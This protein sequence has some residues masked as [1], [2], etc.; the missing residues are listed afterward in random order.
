MMVVPEGGSLFEHNMT[1]VVDGHTGVEHSI[2]VAKGYEDVRQLWSSTKVGY[3]P[4]LIV[5]YGGLWGEQYWY[6]KTNVWE[7]QRLSTF[8]PRRIIDSRSRRRT[9]APD[10][11]WNHLNNARLAGDLLHR[12]VSVQLGAHGQRE[13][14][15]AHW[16][17]WMFAQGGM[18]PLEVIRCATLNGARYLGLDKD[19][20]SLEPG[21]LAD[22]AVLDGNP[23][24]NIRNTETV[25][26]TVVNGRV[27]DA[28]TMNEI[29]NHPHTRQPF[30]FQTPGNEGWGRAAEAAVNA[31]DED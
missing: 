28:A 10:D 27:F 22:L 30:F 25:H 24:E 8:V 16:E 29:G 13:G 1:M 3:T 7:D 9:A 11:E 20:G 2:P 18:T 26:Y 4:T 19:I 5:G 21:K 14:L 23:L 12:G 31:E 17:M 6:A 15:G